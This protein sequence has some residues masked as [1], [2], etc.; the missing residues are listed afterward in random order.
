MYSLHHLANN[1][2][3]ARGALDACAH[4]G[5]RNNWGGRFIGESCKW[6]PGCK[7]TPRQRK[8]NFYEMGEIW[9]VGV[10]NLVLLACVLMVTTKKGQLFWGTKVHPQRKSW[11]HLYNN[12]SYSLEL[13]DGFITIEHRLTVSNTTPNVSVVTETA[14]L[15]ILESCDYRLTQPGSRHV[16]AVKTCLPSSTVGY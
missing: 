10:V 13:Q 11:L 6:T 3:V 7:C 2:G 1:S 9:R 16:N 8:S 12:C 14:D 4:P 5:R 15:C